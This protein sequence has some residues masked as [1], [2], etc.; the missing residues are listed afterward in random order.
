MGK[1]G[2]PRSPCGTYSAFRRHKRFKEEPCEACR[3]AARRYYQMRF[4]VREADRANVY[5]FDPPKGWRHRAA[6]VGSDPAM[7]FPEDDAGVAECV[8]VCE[9]CPVRQECLTA[10][11]VETRGSYDEVG[12]RGG[13]TPAERKSLRRMLK[14]SA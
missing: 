2:R 1:G 13:L 3:R 8:A 7:W 11:L 10:A 9:G 4:T 12:V 6:C 5:A 14:V